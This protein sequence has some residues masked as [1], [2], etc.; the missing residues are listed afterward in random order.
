[1][2]YNRS[3]FTEKGFNEEEYARYFRMNQAEYIRRKLRCLKA[4]HD[5]ME[6]EEITV[7]YGVHNQTARSY[8][9][10]YLAGGFDLLCQAIV[11]PKKCL[12]TE[13]ECLDFA[14]VLLKSPKDAGM[15]GNI[16]TGLMMCQYL[17]KTYNVEYKSG[18]YDLLERLGMTHQKAHSDYENADIEQQRAFLED[19]KETILSSDSKTAIVKFDEFSICEKPT[20]YY[21]WAR[22]NTRP[23]YV[24]NEKKENE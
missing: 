20:S 19:F 18:I 6:Y 22:K 24:T 1:M 9:N 3:K 7:K 17:K 15:E 14:E 5:G 10:C 23:R 8:I 13:S 4:Y 2:G 16:W 21:G 12:L 11:R